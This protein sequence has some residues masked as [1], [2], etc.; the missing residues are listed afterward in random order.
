MSQNLASKTATGVQWSTISTIFN[1]V[2]QLGYGAIM[3]RLL[4]PA[5]FGL[6]AIMHVV[7]RF[8]DYFAK[9][10]MSQAIIQKKELSNYEV[11]AG[12]TLSFFLGLF[13]MVLVYFLAPFVTEFFDNERLVSVIRYAS[14]SFLIQGISSTAISLLTRELEFKK[15]AI[16]TIVSYI[17]G[18]LCIGVT[19]AIY[20]FGVY[21]L[22][23]AM[24]SQVLLNGI[25]SYAVS[26]HS[27]LFIFKKQYFM[28]LLSYGSK[29]SVISFL[30]FINLSLD[31]LLIEKFLGTSLLGFY[32][33]ATQLVYLP[34]YNL[35]TSLSKVMLPSFSKIQDDLKKLGKTYQGIISGI[36]ALNL[37][38]CVFVILTAEDIINLFLGDGWEKS[39]P[40]LKIMALGV[41]LRMI[42][43]FAGVICD[44]TANLRIRMI[45]NIYQ[46]VILCVSFYF[47]MDLG[48]IGF[49][50]AVVITQ[51]ANTIFYLFVMN[52]ILKV[53]I[54]SL[55]GAFSTGII[56]SLITGA[57]TYATVSFAEY[58][59][60]PLLIK[61]GVEGVV[62]VIAF[63]ISLMFN[64]PKEVLH[65]LI[66]L[67][68][69]QDAR[70]EKNFMSKY[71]LNYKFFLEEKLKK[72][73]L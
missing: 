48:L 4:D 12:F 53:S 55:I 43:M 54:P 65:H 38:L 31:K 6:V 37:P 64:P 59:E 21:S 25:F 20:D 40:I 63:V 24:M 3:A 36:S 68:N 57:I 51:I 72:H 61:F 30:D 5:E 16:I 27:V 14:V 9:M 47:L 18:Y 41:S 26:R 70:F 67:V 50:F 44:A 23:T 13:S 15:L 39:I 19:M 71:Y 49:A 52:S 32:D 35:S 73:S 22:I 46:M 29:M 45:N 34:M 10:G 33:R 62:F 60:L 11:R 8:V 7:L 56:I 28:S 66:R 17:I 58:L 42:N 1:A 69:K 2:M